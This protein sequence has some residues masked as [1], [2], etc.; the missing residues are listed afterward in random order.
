M[1]S[2]AISQHGSEESPLYT[3]EKISGKGLGMRAA[4]PIKVGTRILE[5]EILM[6]TEIPGGLSQEQR[7]DIITRAYTWLNPDKQ[8]ALLTLFD[9]N[10]SPGHR[11]INSFN[12]NAL[13]VY[14]V[15]YVVSLQTSRINHSCAPNAYLTLNTSID[16]VTLHATVDILAGQE[17]TVCYTLPHFDGEFRTWDRGFI[18]KCIVCQ[19]ED[20]EAQ[21]QLMQ[22]TWCSLYDENGHERNSAQG[23]WKAVIEMIGLMTAERLN[24]GTLSILYDRAAEICLRHFNGSKA[25]NLVKQ[26]YTSEVCRLGS[27]H[28]QTRD[29]KQ[30]MDNLKALVTDDL[31]GI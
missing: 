22:Q 1:S 12:A 3:V 27:D 23:S 15:T 17:I 29:T 25:L 2:T 13:K 10:P 26:K 30:Y 19:S 28:P 20:K 4:K 31:S 18:C 24:V 11:V 9:P 6:R 7:N 8:K 14:N 16:R 21:R 5:D